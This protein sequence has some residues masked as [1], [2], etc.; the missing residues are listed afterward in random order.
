MHI[1]WYNLDYESFKDYVSDSYF[2]D[3]LDNQ[4][5]VSEGGAEDAVKQFLLDALQ[6]YDGD[7]T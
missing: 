6:D 5:G 4:I 3:G 7:K 1:L 2:L